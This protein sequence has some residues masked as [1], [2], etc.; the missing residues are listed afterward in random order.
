M[1]Q[2]TRSN[3]PRPRQLACL[4]A[5]AAQTGTSFTYPKTVKDAS[6]EI[7]RLLALKNSGHAPL[8]TPIDDSP[9]EL[10]YATAVQPG[11][12]VGFGSTASWRKAPPPQTLAPA[13]RSARVS[14]LTVHHPAA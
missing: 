8:P 10:L 4:K 5:L 13:R 2:T 6:R 9:S 14:E 7:G 3:A 1:S 12:V 11:E